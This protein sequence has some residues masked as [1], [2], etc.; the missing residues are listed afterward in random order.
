MTCLGKK[1][2]LSI[3]DTVLEEREA[4]R[5]KT[6]KIG[7]IARASSLYGVDIIEVFRDEKRK[8]EGRLIRRVL[9]YL[10][11]P[12]YLRKRI[13]PLDES[14]RFAG[15]LPPL[16]I[17]SHKP[18]VPV[19]KLRIGEFREGVTNSDGTVDIGLEGNPKLK[20]G[21]GVDR[22]VTVKLTSV[23]PLE[24]ELVRRD[25][26]SEYWGYSVETRSL[27][28]VLSDSRFVLKI[29]TSRYGKALWGQLP[30][31]HESIR[32]AAGIKLIFGS[33]A[34]GLF[35]L[36]GADLPKLTDYVL[37]LFTDQHVETVRTE[38]AIF[39]G[40]NL[41]NMLVF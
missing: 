12:Q 26:V 19:E 24:A 4:L 20:G 18:K 25:E 39:A 31:L 36:A 37:N 11:T 16:R 41:V 33:P 1:L 23:S 13:Y 40:L 35:D 29:A 8:G 17:P 2:A 10:E 21:A 7:V 27:D 14:F 3:P 32:G 38:E 22:R 6:V 34:R 30:Q 9:E 28:E 15:L 5:D